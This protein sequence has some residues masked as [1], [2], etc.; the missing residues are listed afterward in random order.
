MRGNLMQIGC[1]IDIRAVNAELCGCC[2]RVPSQLRT[3]GLEGARQ[4]LRR[5]VFYVLALNG[6]RLPRYNGL[7]QQVSTAPF[8]AWCCYRGS[9]RAKA[10]RSV[11]LGQQLLL[12]FA[13]ACYISQIVEFFNFSTPIE[14][15]YADLYPPI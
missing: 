1:L 10:T 11:A 9:C 4:K 15:H 6:R 8:S 14:T 7:Q 2:F 13:I 5:R 3:G 12:I